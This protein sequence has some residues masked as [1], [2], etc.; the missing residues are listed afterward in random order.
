MS[1][2]GEYSV[3]GGSIMAPMRLDPATCYRAMR[4]R[5]A[6]FDGRFFVAVSSTRIYCRPVCTVRP[7]RRENCRYYPSAAAAE[8]AG[9]RPCLRCRPE[10][11]PGNATIDAVQRTA[12]AAALLIE[13]GSVNEAGIEAAAERLGITDRHL[14]RAF[15]AEFGVSPVAF[16]QTQRLLLAKQLLTDTRMPVTEVAFASGFGSV[17]RFNALFRERYRLRPRELRK[18]SLPAAGD[19]LAFELGYRPPYD[20]DAIAGFLGARAVAGVE[21]CDN[22]AYR[23]TVRVASGGTWHT[24]WVEIAPARGKPALRVRI[25]ASLGK[26]LPP[27]LA[28]VKSLM[29]LSCHPAEV[30]RALGPLAARRPGMRVPG[31]FDG[32]EIA[33]RAI[34]GQQVSVAAARTL[35]GR[36]AEAFGDRIETPFDSLKT[37]FPAADRIAALP[38]R[39]IARLGV[40]A[41]RARSIAALARAVA[42]GGLELAPGADVEAALAKLRALPG[43]GEW[44]AQYIA[45]RALAWPDAFPHTDYGVMKAMKLADPKRVLAAAEGWRPW[46]AYAVMH[47]WRS[48]AGKERKGDRK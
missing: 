48:L 27:V 44:T 30:A 9:Y 37:A 32:F 41:A 25:A 38:L 47:L 39:S 15:Q 20:W 16:A 28:R 22:A 2:N 3:A 6:R 1:E 23:R 14:R 33:L 21:A 34:L 19:A 17:R 40:P 7:P 31:A 42:A 43:V 12:R 36:F 5:D 13:E 26:A 4:A 45:L 35:A 11:A 8:S 46:R 29:D 18:A 10:L 24:G